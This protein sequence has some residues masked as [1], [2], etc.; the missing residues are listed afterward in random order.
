MKRKSAVFPG[1]SLFLCFCLL[2]GAERLF[3]RYTTQMP[4][5][6]L[7]E[8]GIFGLPALLITKT[9]KYGARR[10][11]ICLKLRRLPRRGTGFA[12]RLGAMVG[13][14]SVCLNV[15]L[16]RMFDWT[17]DLTVHIALDLPQFNL[18]FLWKL[19]IT[20]L[21][22]PIMEELYL[23]GTLFVAHETIAGTSVC[24]FLNGVF[25]AMLHGDY[26]NCVGPLLAGMAYAYLV[27]AFRNVWAAV[28]AHMVSNFY[29]WLIDWLLET[30][31]AFGIWKYFL[32]V[33]G[34]LLLLFI[35][36]SLRSWER[37]LIRGT[38]PHFK[39]S[40]GLFDVWLL[41]RNVG[42]LA[43]ILAFFCKVVLH[44]I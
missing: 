40:A 43:F 36:L 2:T 44:V 14:A 23:R 33:N 34:L 37:L 21:I 38:I 3:I 19:L 18:T 22:A 13:M 29:Y 39:Q 17:H 25:F 6:A 28:L 9:Q 27:F 15:L 20:V 26:T 24:L 4:L 41:L 8:V 5:V 16:A 12:I 1:L 11:R 30:Y 32:T 35:Y 31:A 7:A 42:T 10:M